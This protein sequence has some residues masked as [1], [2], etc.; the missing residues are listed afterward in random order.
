MAEYNYE[1]RASSQSLRKALEDYAEAYLTN[2]YGRKF[3]MSDI[4]KLADALGKA[5]NS[6]SSVTKM[7][8]EIEASRGDLG[9]E[10]KR[11]ADKLKAKAKIVRRDAVLSPEDVLDLMSI[12]HQIQA[13]N[14]EVAFSMGNNLDTIVRDE[15]P[16][17]VWRYLGGRTL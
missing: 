7:L 2:T 4:P 14:R 10:A 17:D 3:Q 9:S 16:N 15:I 1:R 6:S 13:G 5:I 12:A 8:N 11:M